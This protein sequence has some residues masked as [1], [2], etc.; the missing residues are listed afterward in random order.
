VARIKIFE[1]R[2]RIKP[3]SLEKMEQLP[4][5]KYRRCSMSVEI[6]QTDI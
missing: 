1:L 3:V 4:V 2:D 6:Q 5:A